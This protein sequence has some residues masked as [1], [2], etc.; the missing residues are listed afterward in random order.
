LGF[1]ISAKARQPRAFGVGLLAEEVAHLFRK[2][3][4]VAEQEKK[5]RKKKKKKRAR[6]AGVYQ[7]VNY[8]N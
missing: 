3:K 4:I 8:V 7:S 6:A 5:K 2:K 1:F